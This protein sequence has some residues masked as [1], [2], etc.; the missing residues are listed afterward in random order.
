MSERQPLVG[1]VV[2][3]HDDLHVFEPAD[4]L[5]EHLGVGREIRIRSPHRTP[6]LTIEYAQAAKERGL[7]VIIAA[8]GGS[9]AALPGFLA[10]NT[11]L[12]VLGV[13]VENTSDSFHAA[14]GSMTNM[15]KGIPVAFMGIGEEG[16]VNA[17]H[18]ALRN[19]ALED[20]VLAERYGSLMR[21]IRARVVDFDTRLQAIGLEPFLSEPHAPTA[22]LEDSE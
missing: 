7:R 9:A 10:A 22:S 5:F 21:K 1:M 3:S 15:P 13:A 4:K 6:D 8:A 16:A 18:H 19:L 20:V 2:A 14:M 12:T 17:A 11:E